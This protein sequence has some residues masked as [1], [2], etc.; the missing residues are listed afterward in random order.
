M[1]KATDLAWM[2]G[3]AIHETGDRLEDGPIKAAREGYRSGTNEY[4]AFITA[5]SKMVNKTRQKAA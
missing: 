1:M 4:A 2:K 3:E 5:F